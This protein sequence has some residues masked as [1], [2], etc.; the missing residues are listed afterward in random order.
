MYI[1]NG[2]YCYANSA[3]MLMKSV[4]EDVH[5]SLLEVL[6]GVGLGVT[7]YGNGSLFLHNNTA[8]PDVAI[9]KAMEIAGFAFTE[10]FSKADA[11]CPIDEM[12]KHIEK[13]PAML[14]PI[15][16]GYLTYSPNHQF[17]QGA[18]HYVLAYRMDDKYVYVHDPANFPYV[19]LPIEMLKKA[20]KAE[21]IAYGRGRYQYW[22]SIRRVS[23]PSMDEI[24][25][26]S[27]RFFQNIYENTG[28]IGKQIGAKTGKAAIEVF[29]EKL[30][31]NEISDDAIGNLKFFVFQ[32]GAKRAN[33]FANYF[34]NRNETLSQLKRQQAELLGLCHS[35]TMEG[36]W[37]ELAS[38]LE[39]FGILEE[40]FE[41]EIRG[42]HVHS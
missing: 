3:S 11:E 41:G 32:L 26:A 31:S 19:R 33:D 18:D 28:E 20:W 13:S 22:H 15:D 10:V 9:S 37:K 6:S 23:N 8:D 40:A 42:L 21:N 39:K 17:Q 34:E 36:D 12:K 14:G 30:R 7:M 27:I 24:Y 5:P 2:A 35:L 16:M 29:V 1:G 25:D 4:G 38:V